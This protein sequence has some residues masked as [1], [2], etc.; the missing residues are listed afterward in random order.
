MS[1]L[2]MLLVARKLVLSPLYVDDRLLA[3]VV[4]GER[5]KSWPAVRAMLER[6]GMPP[7][8]RGFGGLYYLP[9]QLH[10]LDKREGIAA[11]NVE[12]GYAEDGPANFG[13]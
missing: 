1:E 5:A 7:A 11:S 8:R 13:P 4:L 2:K 3:E 10:F 9:A 6:E 12:G